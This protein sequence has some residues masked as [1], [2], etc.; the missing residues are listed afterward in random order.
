M[1][2][3]QF[4]Q[5]QKEKHVSYFNLPDRNFDLSLQESAIDFCD[6]MYFKIPRQGVFQTDKG[7]PVSQ[8]KLNRLLSE[9]SCISSTDRATLFFNAMISLIKKTPKLS[10]HNLSVSKFEKEI[11]IIPSNSSNQ[12]EK[13]AISVSSRLEYKR[14]GCYL[15]AFGNENY[16][17]VFVLLSDSDNDNLESNIEE[18]FIPQYL[19][20]L[21]FYCL[22]SS[23]TTNA[24]PP[25]SANIPSKT[26]NILRLT[27]C[28]A[29]SQ[30]I[31]EQLY[32]T[33]R[34]VEYH[35]QR[36]K[37]ILNASNKVELVSLAKDNCLI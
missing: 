11:N 36:A 12:L 1:I 4:I 18:K 16:I 35:L 32:L 21:H 30:E 8:Q 25:I 29:S 26:L 3:V 5:Y 14:V 23:V 15:T 34:G 9:L 28:G 31:A 10:L 37:E 2:R 33:T 22:R 24:K 7:N 19:D 20:L 17:G 6:L 13:M 27:S